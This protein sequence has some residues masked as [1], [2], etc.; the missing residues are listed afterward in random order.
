MIDLSTVQNGKPWPGNRLSMAGAAFEYSTGEFLVQVETDND[1]E[2]DAIIDEKESYFGLIVAK[3][4]VGL[5]VMRFGVYQYSPAFHAGLLPKNERRPFS[6]MPGNY[7]GIQVA[8]IQRKTGIV[9]GQRYFT[10][11]PVMAKRLRVLVKAQVSRPMSMVKFDMLASRVRYTYP[12][13]HDVRCAAG[14]V[15]KIGTNLV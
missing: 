4:R 13:D 10:V 1:R 9:W 3:G 2:A 6:M 8:V 14:T 12:T 11:S 15:E 5:A 7:L